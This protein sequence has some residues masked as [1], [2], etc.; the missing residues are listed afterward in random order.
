MPLSA[1]DS[2]KASIMKE[3]DSVMYYLGSSEV[4]QQMHEALYCSYFY[5]I[6]KQLF[7]VKTREEN[8]KSKQSERSMCTA[9]K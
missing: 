3:D 1:V 7:S 9:V 6:Y 4:Q 2:L 8:T 5:I